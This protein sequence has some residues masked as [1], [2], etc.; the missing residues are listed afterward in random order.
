MFNKLKIIILFLFINKIC[1]CQIFPQPQNLPFF[2][3]KPIHFGF[4]VGL[5]N[6]DFKIRPNESSNDQ[7]LNYKSKNQYGFNLG[8]ISNIKLS[9]EIDFRILPSLVFAE[10]IIEYQ[11][12]QENSILNINKTIESTFI[13]IPLIIKYKSERYNNGRAFLITGIKYSYDLASQKNIDDGGNDIIKINSHDILY[14]FGG[15]IDFYFEYFKFS[16]QVKSSI[17][18]LNVLSEENLIYSD[19][20]NKLKTRGINIC[21]LFE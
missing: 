13:D 3:K 14:E 10:R 1:F 12:I 8:I 19:V 9:R 17:G 18:I 6:Y 11:I 16:I 2:D 20:L 15:G 21:F 5:N 7:I 4:L